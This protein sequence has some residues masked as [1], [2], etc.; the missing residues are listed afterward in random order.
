MAITVTGPASNLT[1][2]GTGAVSTA[3]VTGDDLQVWITAVGGAR[4]HRVPDAAITEVQWSETLAAMPSSSATLNVDRYA[5]LDDED[6]DSWVVAEL[7]RIVREIQIV[8]QGRVVFWGPI[9]SLSRKPGEATVDVSCSGCEYWFGSRLMMLATETLVG[10]GLITSRGRNLDFEDE[11]LGWEI[12]TPTPVSNNTDQ[13]S[14]AF[15]IDLD[16]GVIRQSLSYVGVVEWRVT[17]RVKV[18]AAVADPTVI[19]R[20]TSPSSSGFPTMTTEVTAAEAPRDAWVTLQA[21]LPTE[22]SPL[23]RREARVEVAALGAAAGEVLANSVRLSPAIVGDTGQDGHFGMWSQRRAWMDI[24]GRL[25]GFGIAATADLEG[26]P[27]ATEWR[28]R[29]V[30]ASEA[31]RQLVDT[32]GCEVEMVLT[33]SARVAALRIPL[34]GVEHDPGTFALEAGTAGVVSVDGWSTGVDRPVTEWTIAD[35]AGREGTYRDATLFGGLLI[36]N[37]EAAPT[38]TDPDALDAR[39]QVTGE[40]AGSALIEQM[41]LTVPMASCS[42]LQ[43]GDRIKV[44]VDDGPDQYAD[45]MRV[46]AKTVDPAAAGFTVQVNKWVA[47]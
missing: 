13:E 19:L 42:D 14:G 47:P 32:G 43:V 2:G 3:T 16:G 44:T 8:H 6:P 22:T 31:A 17:L 41:S 25:D 11:L 20:V 30:F 9:L 12:I 39:A 40:R 38:G 21:F 36:Q 46:E 34:R 10:D 24:V 29:D 28:R 1:L 27:I 35:D 37:Y 4:L 33:P 7:Q 18:A 15:C 5:L 23:V 45:L 26:L